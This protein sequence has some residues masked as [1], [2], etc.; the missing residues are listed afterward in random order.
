VTPLAKR[1][2]ENKIRETAYKARVEYEASY[3]SWA[4][5]DAVLSRTQG[6][7]LRKTFAEWDKIDTQIMRATDPNRDRSLRRW[8]TREGLDQEEKTH[9]EVLQAK[10]DEA[11]AELCKAFAKCA[12]AD[13]D[14]KDTLAELE[15][16]RA[17]R[18]SARA[19]RD[20]ARAERLEQ[21]A[22]RKAFAHCRL[23][24]VS[25]E[26]DSARAEWA[27]MR[28]ERDALAEKLEALELDS[29]CRVC[30][31]RPAEIAAVPCGRRW[32]T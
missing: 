26:R 16:L 32:A 21:D 8:Q 6:A 2:K 5:V 25:A 19:E 7:E 17:E 9:V 4:S 20:S 23:S 12:F 29:T 31:D 1:E 22:L 27:A 11:R 28:A 18:D 10:R 30:L 14:A 3:S 24:K 15:A 13:W